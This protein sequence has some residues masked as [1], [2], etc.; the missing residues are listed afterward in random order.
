MEW[1]KVAM[2]PFFVGLYWTKRVGECVERIAKVNVLEL[3]RQLTN[4][5]LVVSLGV[6][7]SGSRL[8]L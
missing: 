2:G 1:P 4:L 6:L 8:N 3:F 7:L 5:I